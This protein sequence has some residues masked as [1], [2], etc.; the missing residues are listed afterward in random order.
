[1][2]PSTRYRNATAII[3]TKNSATDST[4]ET[5]S[6]LHGSIRRICML[7][8]TGPRG[9]VPT[10]T[11]P[12]GAAGRLGGS[13]VVRSAGGL[14]CGG[15]GIGPGQVRQLAGVGLVGDQ[16]VARRGHGLLR[17]LG[18]GGRRCGRRRG[19]P[20]RD[21]AVEPGV[22]TG[23]VTGGA[24]RGRSPARPGSP[25]G[26]LR[27]LG[28]AR[29]APLPRRDVGG[30]GDPAGGRTG[31][32]RAGPRRRVAE[33]PAVMP[34]PAAEPLPLPGPSP[35][36]GYPGSFGELTYGSLAQVVTSRRARRLRLP[37]PPRRCAQWQPV[38]R[39][40]PGSSSE[41]PWSAARPCEPGEPR[42]G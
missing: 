7:A 20:A 33:R 3:Q 9:W 15:R 40:H 42:S 21:E 11:R 31:R 37:G 10:W 16:L 28:R 14:R 26:P 1:M 32:R 34:E 41:H 25:A 23:G 24:A 17:F 38:C 12:V 22:D 36:R 35:V 2:P 5:F 8:R 19:R 30:V 6:A 18:C 39:P 27:W 13:D 4:S 29:R